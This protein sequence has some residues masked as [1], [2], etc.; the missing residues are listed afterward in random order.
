[1]L[2]AFNAL[3]FI[4]C[5]SMTFGHATP[6]VRYFTATLVPSVL[7]TRAPLLAADSLKNL[8]M[9]RAFNAFSLSAQV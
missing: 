6:I 7:Q 4:F 8:V 5:P 3:S 9:L 1:M 2:R